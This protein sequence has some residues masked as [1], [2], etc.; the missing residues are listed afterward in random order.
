MQSVRCPNS[1]LMF[2]PVVSLPLHARNWTVHHPTNGL[3]GQLMKRLI[4]EKKW[5][6][7]YDASPMNMGWSSVF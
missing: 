4:N 1:D 7:N 3:R 5:L 2:W 6:P